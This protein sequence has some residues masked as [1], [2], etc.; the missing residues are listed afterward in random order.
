MKKKYIIILG[1]V[2]ILLI[3]GISII[4]AQQQASTVGQ[5]ATTSSQ[6]TATVTSPVPTLALPPLTGTAKEATA[7][8]YK[9]YTSSA[10]NPMSAGAFKKSP[11][12]TSEFK[13]TIEAAYDNGNVPIFC[14]TNIRKNIVVGNESTYYYDNGYNTREVISDAANPSKQLFSVILKPVNNTWQIFDIDCLQ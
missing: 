1:V 4:F 10:Q 6:Q 7:Q 3:V 14:P 5:E 9:Y 11:Y 8:F 2:V 13:E 12:L